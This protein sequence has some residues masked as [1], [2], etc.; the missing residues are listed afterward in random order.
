MAENQ[1]DA[2]VRMEGSIAAIDLS[3]EINAF[4]E[5][6]L[7]HAYAEASSG[8]SGAVLLNFSAINY[9]NSTGIALIVALLAQAR[10]NGT[11]LLVYGL[12][13]HYRELFH[14]TRLADFM[15]LL[16]DEQTAVSRVTQS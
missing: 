6:R 12:S 8:S 10:K 3:G 9:I 7:N 4:A 16:P 1:F 14:I 2:K 15:E 5:E 11:R 13:D